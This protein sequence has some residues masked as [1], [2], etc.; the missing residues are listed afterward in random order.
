MMLKMVLWKEYREHRSIWLG[1]AAV[2]AAAILG[3]GYGIGFQGQDGAAARDLLGAAVLVLAWTYG[4]VC[5][6]LL[7]AGERESG[8]QP[9]LDTLPSGRLP[10]WWCKLA[11]GSLL[12]LAQVAFLAALGTWVG[13]T[14]EVGWGVGVGLL[15]ASAAAGFGWGTL[16]SS[17]APTPL[18]AIALAAASQVSAAPLL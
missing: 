2:A 15:L 4:A 8:T 13:L 3:V 9:F 1:M 16:F 11:A 7:L 17:H 10:L 5:G 6:S 12:V 14:T 18:V